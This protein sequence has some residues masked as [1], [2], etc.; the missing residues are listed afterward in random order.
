M[1]NKLICSECGE[2][3]LLDYIIVDDKLICDTCQIDII[4]EVGKNE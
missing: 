4:I 1:I 2:P 3:I